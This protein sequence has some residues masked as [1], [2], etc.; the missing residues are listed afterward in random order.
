MLDI[1]L[2][3]FKLP[4]RCA[5]CGS[6]DANQK[7]ITSTTKSEYGRLATYRFTLPLCA[8]CTAILI[9]R[10]QM[11]TKVMIGTALVVGGVFI[12]AILASSS[13]PTDNTK[14]LVLIPLALLLL[15]LFIAI[16][17]LTYDRLMTFDGRYFNFTNKEFLKD[18]ADLN[19]NLVK[20]WRI[21]G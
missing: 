19:P 16:R 15:G 4:N 3:D 7:W 14:L 5:R 17:F 13:E 1:D 8:D 20:I 21:K 10:H 11:G 6:Y 2:I 12:L 9:K 18:F